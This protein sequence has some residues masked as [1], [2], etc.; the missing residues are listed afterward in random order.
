MM[1]LNRG[2]RRWWRAEPRHVCPVSAIRPCAV[3]ARRKALSEIRPHCLGLGSRPIRL[4]APRR[5]S[6]RVEPL[7]KLL[8]SLKGGTCI[9]DSL[10]GGKPGIEAGLD[11]DR[12]GAVQRSGF[13]GRHG[14]AKLMVFKR[15]V[16]NT[17]GIA[18]RGG[19]D[20]DRLHSPG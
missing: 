12:R 14:K 2:A 11:E 15:K 19:A 20:T 18:V 17:D 10:D 4:R 5:D 1:N 3:F 8:A 9:D 13:N 16:K 7:P 6:F